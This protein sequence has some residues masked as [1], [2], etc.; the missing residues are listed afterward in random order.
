MARR[1]TDEE[2]RWPAAKVELWAI[3][4]LKAYARNARA[5]SAAQVSQI[6]AS[7]REWGFTVPILVDETGTVIAGH[8]RLRAAEQLKLA[9]VPVMVAR[10]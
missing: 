9:R 8:A 6:V 7:M 4:R 5:H 3:D 1:S 10:G 2:Q